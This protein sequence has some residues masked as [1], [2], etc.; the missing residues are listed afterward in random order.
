MLSIIDEVQ[1]KTAVKTQQT[2]RKQF[3]PFIG[4]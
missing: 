3:A 1:H 4:H 2:S